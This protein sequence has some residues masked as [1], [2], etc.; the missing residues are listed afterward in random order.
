MVGQRGQRAQ[1]LH[2]PSLDNCPLAL[3]ELAFR[4]PDGL[5]NI[6]N[7]K[8]A[9]K[10]G[11]AWHQDEHYIPTRDRSLTAAWIALDDATLENGCLWVLPG[12]HRLGVIWPNR[13]HD[14]EEFDE[15]WETYGYPFAD[16]EVIPCQVDAGSVVFFHGYLLHRSFRNRSR[17]G[18]RRVLVNHYMS[19]ES[20]LPWDWDGR[21][22]PTRDNRDIIMVCGS[23]PYAYKGTEDLTYPLLRA[24]TAS[25]P[26]RDKHKRVY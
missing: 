16:G 14:R 6:F 1:P 20:L 4:L 17:T 23:D 13:P 9:G 5:I 3:G 12:S 21:L 8:S 24:E 10:P 25:D 22:E 7:L 18:F 11:Q 2:L 26:L 15:G 19:A